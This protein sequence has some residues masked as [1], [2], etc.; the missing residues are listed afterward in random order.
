M[1]TPQPYQ[2]TN[3]LDGVPPLPR[4]MGPAPQAKAE[5]HDIKVRVHG[6][7]VQA[8]PK[9]PVAERAETY[10]EENPAVYQKFCAFVL[11]LVSAKKKRIGAKMIAERLRWESLISGN[12]GFK[13]NNSYVAHMAR[14][15]CK[16]Y[17]QHTGVFQFRGGEVSA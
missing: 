15:F 17:P 11:E 16:D 8:K 10:I 9:K 12:D 3:F 5:P 2:F 6:N 7:Q 14:R 4:G 1:N 13:V